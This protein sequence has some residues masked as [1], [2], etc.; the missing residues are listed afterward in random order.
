MFK[1]VLLFLLILALIGLGVFG[2]ILRGLYSILFGWRGKS[3]QGGAAGGGRQ[4]EGPR[5]RFGRAPAPQIRATERILACS[6]CG[7]HVPESEGVRTAEAF[8]CCE[9]HRRAYEKNKAQAPDE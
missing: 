3:A 9:E 7:V 2:L 1:L 6:V 4:P 5:F 8:F